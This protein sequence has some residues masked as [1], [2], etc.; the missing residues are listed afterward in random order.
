[1]ETV[2]LQLEDNTGRRAGLAIVR[3]SLEQLNSR[4]D[5]A[6]LRVNMITP[7]LSADAALQLAE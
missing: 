6:R 7:R 5:H 4:A 1:M 2:N 3:R